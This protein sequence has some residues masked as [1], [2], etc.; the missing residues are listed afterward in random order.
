VTSAFIAAF[1]ALVFWRVL[2]GP[3]KKPLPPAPAVVA[4]PGPLPLEPPVELLRV[5]NS[6]LPCDVDEVLAR[7][8]RRCHTQPPRH[9]APLQL[10]RWE[11]TQA[12]RGGVPV[13]RHLGRVVASGFMPYPIM[14]NPP[15]ERLTDAEKKTLLDWVAAGGPRGGCGDDA[16]ADAGAP[17][18]SRPAP[19]E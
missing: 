3:K 14:A 5:E 16:G 9:N 10:L 2:E 6:G 8:C 13:F 15:V 17:A 11:D 19:R 4:P 18:A 12:D 1:A 7:K